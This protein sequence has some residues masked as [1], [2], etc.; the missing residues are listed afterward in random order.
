MA[1]KRTIY[2]VFVASPSDVAQEREIAR[3]VI[4][5]VSRLGA[6]AGLAMEARGWED[7]RA[8]LGRPQELI[9]PEAEAADLFV[10]ILWKRFG[11]A[12]GVAESGT[13]E[14]FQVVRAGRE[15]G[16]DVDAMLYFR[17]VPADMRDDPG[18]QLTKVLDFKRSVAQIGLYHTYASP[19]EFAARLRKD[20][21]AW[22]TE[23]IRG[24][25]RP[26]RA[27]Q[28][29]RDRRTP[30]PEVLQRFLAAQVALHSHLQMTGFETRL[31]MPIELERV[32]VPVRARVAEVSEE[33]GDRLAGGK[34]PAETGTESA[35][36]D[37]EAVWGR[38]RERG[39]QTLVVLGQ[40]GSGKTTL[41]R[42]LLLRTA[43][44]P[45]DLGLGAG[46]LPLLVPLRLVDAAEDLT[47]AL[48]RILQADLLRLPKDFFDEPLE[49]GRALLLLDGLDE[50]ATAG[51]RERVARWIDEQRGLFA[52]CP[53]VVSAR[54]AGYTGNARLTP[55][56]LEASLERFREAEIHAFLER[57]FV[58]VETTLGQPTD[59]FRERGRE[60]AADLARRILEAPEI[61]ALATNP[62]MLQII[63]LVHRDRGALP[64]R[65]VELYDECTNVLLEHWDRAKAGL[66]IPLTAREARRV[67]Q[68]IAYWMHQEPERRFASSRQLLPLLRQGL[69]ALPR[70]KVEAEEFLTA[71][72]DRSGLFVGHGVDEYGFQH[73]SFQE[74]LAAREVRR[75]ERYRDL[76]RRYG[77]SWWREVTRLLMGLDDPPCFVPFMKSLV[78][79]E[80][81]L[82]HHDLT[83]ACIQDAF[84]P[85]SAPFLA[86]LRATLGKSR[87]RRDLGALQYH[88]LLALRALP[89]ARLEGAVAVLQRAARLAA[90]DEARALATELLAG[91]G[92]EVAPEKDEQS[93]LAT[94]VFNRDATELVL[95]P[96]GE[97]VAGAE[98]EVDNPPRRMRLPSFYLAR[99]PVTNAQYAEYLKA[100][101][102]APKPEHWDDERF[103][104]PQQPVV[105]VSWDEAA[106]YCRWAGLRLPTEWQWEKGARGPAPAG[107][108][109]GHRFPW[110][111]EH[112]DESRANFG[113]TVGRPTPVGSYPSG[114]SPYG[115]LDMAGNVWEWTASEYSRDP[116]ESREARQTRRRG[117]PSEPRSVR[118]GS[119]GDEAQILRAAFR[120]FNFPVY[121]GGLLG[122]RCAQDP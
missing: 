110:G 8:G 1:E 3:A 43:R 47:I 23:R 91:L 17:E 75:R 84:E 89:R 117:S 52:A 33:K 95:I 92:V 37:F 14:E 27:P 24:V 108:T 116:L 72:R 85:S 69:A 25:R 80:R 77:E 68:P 63:A 103:N 114:A 83:A 9:N 20:L 21:G 49:S 113:G 13:E 98:E 10:G 101:S 30:H 40:P 53:M 64:E 7:V 65:R 99:H 73:L 19:E 120:Y 38:A 78:A 4:E 94:V 54:F 2:R 5:E 87:K 67:L 79:S 90:T 58:T 29:A 45:G 111:D 41:L 107:G 6:D 119:F 55:P 62:L 15:I 70:K 81:F 42:Q 82:R 106:A 122:F 115:L 118:G 32:L 105:G 66:D 31:R 112:P 56:H 57:W 39:I 34:R 50:V 74:F 121:R 104:Q 59:F 60:T 48:R 46:T 12:T 51:D 22:F 97:F 16:R 100:H 109:K 26:N 96:G 36:E 35:V 28:R 18:P 11:T 71:I 44:D 102:D 76:V 61:L 86:A 93:G 88:L